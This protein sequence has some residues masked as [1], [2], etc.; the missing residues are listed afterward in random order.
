MSEITRE[1]VAGI[2]CGMQVSGDDEASAVIEKFIVQLETENA[3][4]TALSELLS[5]LVDVELE[6]DKLA[7]K[8]RNIECAE[9]GLT[10]L[11][12]KCD[13]T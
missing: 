10:M 5:H 2:L 6:R 9:C 13:E 12:C 11:E 4:L 1:H 7:D 3:A 8:L